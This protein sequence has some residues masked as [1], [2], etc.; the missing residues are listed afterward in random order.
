M[1]IEYICLLFTRWNL[2]ALDAPVAAP[3]RVDRVAQHARAECILE[4]ARAMILRWGYQ[5]VTMDD[6]A[7]HAAIGTGT[8]YLHWKT[9][10]ALFETVLLHELLAL[11]REQAQRLQADPAEALLHRWLPA[12]LLAI[13]QRPLA[14]ALFTRDT[15]LLGKLAQRQV[16]AQGL[17]L[18]GADELMWL[19]RRLGLMRADLSLAAQTYAFSA[20]WT[21]FVLVDQFLGA[22][23]QATLETQA[24]ALA[25]TI[26]QTFEP[27]TAPDTHTLQEQIAPALLAFLSQIIDAVEQQVQARMVA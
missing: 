5:R 13:K 4:A 25:Y 9:K 17:Q 21:G 24:E 14:R 23:A 16:A 18:T 26:R 10:Q 22:D 15:A 1:N 8:L 19:C 7:R 11:W 12:L 6:I 20:L 3:A 2:M 27:D